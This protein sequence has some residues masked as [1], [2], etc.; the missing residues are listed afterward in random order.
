MNLATCYH[1]GGWFGVQASLPK[2]FKWYRRAAELGLPRAQLI[3]GSFYCFGWGVETN[4]T[5]SFKWYRMAAEQGEMESQHAL[6][7]CYESGADVPKD[8]VEAYKW[9][10]IN[11]TQGNLAAKEDLKRLTNSMTPTQIAE[12][13]RRASE[14]FASQKAKP[15]ATASIARF[16]VGS[17]AGG[18][19]LW[20]LWRQK[21]TICPNPVKAKKLKVA[22]LVIVGLLV[23]LAVVIFLVAL[24]MGLS[25]GEM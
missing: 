23:L 12:A 24:V 19:L 7:S 8:L 13:K 21:N 18:A 3:L 6:G 2:A 9:F 1:Y 5:E 20:V 16:L 17:L 22:A 14:F 11:A 25:S 4:L 15:S 10:N